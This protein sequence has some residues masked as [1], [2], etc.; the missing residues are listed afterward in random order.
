MAANSP[1]ARRPV[2]KR[3]TIVGWAFTARL[4]CAALLLTPTAAL[5]QQARPSVIAIDTIAAIDEVVDSTGSSVTGAIF[6][7]VVSA[8]LGHGFQATVR[9]IAQRRAGVWNRQIWMA[10]VRYERPGTVGFR[11]D[12]G[13]IPSPVGLANLT[14]RPHLNPTISQPSSLFSALPAVQVRGPRANLLGAIYSYG[15]VATVS[16]LHWDARAGVIDA[17]PTRPRE[18]FTETNPPR[19][20][21]VVAG[22]GITPFV[23]FRMGASVTRGG[24]MRAG[25]SPSITADHDATIVTIESEFSF[26]YTKLS[27]EWVRD[28][29]ET[30]SGTRVASG[31]YVQG[32]QTLASRW[33]VA[34]RVERMSSPVLPAFVE[35]HLR[36]VEETLGY[37]LTPEITLRV[38]HRAR[39]GFGRPGYDHQG[40]VSAVWWKR[41]M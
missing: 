32:Q 37:R 19:F 30:D 7:A 31:W 24:W 16:G 36:G 23:G 40:A 28:A 22:G 18:V 15:A 14:L 11:L 10:N 1:N 8:D 4:A 6:D 41:W 5:A 3:P 9:P 20:A 13:L 39:R 25:E 34:G 2:K 21:N 17:S 12:A 35:Q 26:R 33:F 29:L 27:G 38:G